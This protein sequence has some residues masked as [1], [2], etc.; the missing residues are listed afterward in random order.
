MAGLRH[1]FVE[2]AFTGTA[3]AASGL[4]GRP[5]YFARPTRRSKSCPVRALKVG[6]L[7]MHAAVGLL[8]TISL[9]NHLC[10]K[11]KPLITT[12]PVSIRAANTVR[13]IPFPEINLIRQ[14]EAS[15]EHLP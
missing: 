4:R 6:F 10:N 12:K 2:I 7:I 1:L 15:L 8:C 13:L 11:A 3:L 14:K 5:S 9:V